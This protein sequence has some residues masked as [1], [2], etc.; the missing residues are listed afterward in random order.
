LG[1]A[2]EGVVVVVAGAAQ[3]V[4]DLCQ[5]AC[6][7][8]AVAALVQGVLHGFFGGALG[9]AKAHLLQPALGVV[10]V[11]GGKAVA[12]LALDFAAEVV[13]GYRGE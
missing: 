2:V 12:V 10:L 5:L 4:F 6:G 7:V 1:E 3:A 9:F 8:V 13:V 11:F